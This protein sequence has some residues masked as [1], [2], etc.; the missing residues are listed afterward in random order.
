MIDNE[1][2]LSDNSESNRWHY[3]IYREPSNK[4]RGPEIGGVVLSGRSPAKRKED[5][6]PEM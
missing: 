3:L 6:R 5:R 1:T 4:R 2:R